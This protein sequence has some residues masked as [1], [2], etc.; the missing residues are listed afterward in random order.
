[1]LPFTVPLF[2][3]FYSQIT[4]SYTT[5]CIQSCIKFKHQLTIYGLG[6]MSLSL[7][8]R[9]C[10][11]IESKALLKSIVNIHAVGVIK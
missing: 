2:T 8:A 7:F 4:L 9:R 5:L 3:C 10:W 1:M 6:E 11:F